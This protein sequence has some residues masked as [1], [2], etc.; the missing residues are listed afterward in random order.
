MRAARSS[1]RI[2]YEICAAICF[3]LLFSFGMNCYA[4]FRSLAPFLPTYG[5]FISN[6]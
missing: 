5:C 4:F 2:M 1:P 6:F 3:F